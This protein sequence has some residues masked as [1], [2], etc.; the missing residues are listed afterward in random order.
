MW[1]AY[2]FVHSIEIPINRVVFIFC[3]LIIGAVS[4]GQRYTVQQFKIIQI[5]QRFKPSA[6]KCVR[7][8][9]NFFSV[10][11]EHDLFYI[12]V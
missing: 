5:Y 8:S 11:F 4:L 12:V 1:L 9:T 6:F 3:V 7:T 2:S 10:E